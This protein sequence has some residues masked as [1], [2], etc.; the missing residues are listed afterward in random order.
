LF[1]R[2]KVSERL[3][4]A[5]KISI[6]K[7]C[8]IGRYAPATSKHKAVIEREFCGMGEIFKDEEAF[9]VGLDRVCYIPELSDTTYTRRDFLNIAD[10]HEGL[11]RYLFEVVDW[12]T[13]EA[14]FDEIGYLVLEDN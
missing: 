13:P 4:M 3:V 8:K 14:L 9:E 2:R 6:G 12:Q 5:R 7:Y 1:F 11:A 10:G